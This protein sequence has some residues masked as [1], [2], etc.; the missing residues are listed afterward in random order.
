MILANKKADENN[1]AAEVVAFT[2]AQILSAKKYKHRKDALN[3][4]LKDDQTY[5]L[6]E[7]DDLIAN[8]MKEKV[9]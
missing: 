5:S 8:L 6:D 7:V 2:K 3:V 1:Q 4:V 9:N